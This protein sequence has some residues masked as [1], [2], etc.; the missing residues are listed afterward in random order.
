M[1]LNIPWIKSIWRLVQL[2]F[3]IKYF[4]NHFLFPRTVFDHDH[5]L[6]A[7]VVLEGTPLSL[8]VLD[9]ENTET[10]QRPNL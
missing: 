9:L 2:N 8:S 5:D 6:E 4:S 1:P 7:L 3:V 10:K